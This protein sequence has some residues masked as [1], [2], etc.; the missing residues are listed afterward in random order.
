MMNGI[1][2]Q[3]LQD[4]H[5]IIWVVS[6][7]D[8]RETVVVIT[9]LKLARACGIYKRMRSASTELSEVNERR[10]MLQR[11]DLY[12]GEQLGFSKKTA[13]QRKLIGQVRFK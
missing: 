13:P 9:S 10:Y 8:R 3:T 6:N 1:C 11:T 2:A 5:G 7:G 12:S 4:D